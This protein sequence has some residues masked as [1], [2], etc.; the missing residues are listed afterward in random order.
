VLQTTKMMQTA[1]AMDE[2]LGFVRFPDI[3]FRQ[4]GLDVFSFRLDPPRHRAVCDERRRDNHNSLP[5][6]P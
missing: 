4:G 1:W 5:A 2:G 3:D 6:G